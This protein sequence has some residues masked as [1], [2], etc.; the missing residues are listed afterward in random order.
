MKQAWFFLLV[1]NMCTAESKRSLSVSYDYDQGKPENSDE[2]K[3]A[4]RD[5]FMF[6][7]PNKLK[8]N[9]LQ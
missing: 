2:L 3:A 5:A 4:M 7:E 8:K 9:Q 1:E 6:N